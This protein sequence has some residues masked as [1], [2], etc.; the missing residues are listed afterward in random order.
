[1]QAGHDAAPEIRD[2]AVIRVHVPPAPAAGRFKLRGFG[3]VRL[4]FEPDL[5]W[6]GLAWPGL[7]WP[8]L[9]NQRDCGGSEP[10]PL[11]QPGPPSLL[12]VPA[13]QCH[14]VSLSLWR[15]PSQTASG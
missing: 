2:A 9:A 6:P 12:P 13:C 11:R 14:R 5:A 8:Q 3:G 4:N 15:C 7:A 1:M 10:R